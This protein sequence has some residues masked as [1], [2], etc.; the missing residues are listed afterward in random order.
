MLVL[1][2][3]VSERILIGDGIVITLTQAKGKNQT[4]RIG[5]E[6][7]ANVRISRAPPV[8]TGAKGECHDGNRI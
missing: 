1:G 4:T 5:I 6:A 8:A 3:R 7:P 2:R